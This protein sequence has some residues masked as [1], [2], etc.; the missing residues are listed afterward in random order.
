[1][2]KAREAD[3]GHMPRLGEHAGDVPDRLLRLREV[4]SEKHATVLLRKK[5][6]ETPQALGQRAYIKQVNDQQIARLSA[7][8]ADR[9]GEKMNDGQIDVADIVRGFVVLD[10]AAG[11]VIGLD[12]EVVAGLHP[13]HDRD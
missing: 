2:N 12:H 11:P 6:V 7:L 5:A 9:P 3:T 13:G 10:E 4:I 1:M 8:D